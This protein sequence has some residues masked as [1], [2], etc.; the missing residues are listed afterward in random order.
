MAKVP[1]DA[2]IQ[3]DALSGWQSVVFSVVLYSQ[4]VQI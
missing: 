4:I 1:D 3:G 2:G